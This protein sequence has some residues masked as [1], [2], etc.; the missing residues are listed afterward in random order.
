MRGL[1]L[2]ADGAIASVEVA[3]ARALEAVPALAAERVIR[4]AVFLLLGVFIVVCCCLARE[5]DLCELRLGDEKSGTSGS[6]PVIKF[7]R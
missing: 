5:S 4:L 1:G 7:E 6:S 3:I 2:G